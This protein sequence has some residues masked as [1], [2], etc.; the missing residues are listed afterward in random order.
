MPYTTP[1]AVKRVLRGSTQDTDGGT[2]AELDDGQ[3]EL[4]INN[5]Q[6]QID[7]VLANRYKVP[8]N[9]VPVLVES[10]ATDI[11]AYLS[12][13]NYRKSREYESDNYPIIRRYNRARELLEWL[14]TGVATLPIERDPTEIN[15]A[16]VVHQYEGRM[17]IE[18]DVFGPFEREW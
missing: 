16:Y 10:L 12:D 6:A 5:A 18:E 13:L 8:F 2:A 1:D 9:P 3:I 4:E 17:F 15:E 7:S 11:A 14:R